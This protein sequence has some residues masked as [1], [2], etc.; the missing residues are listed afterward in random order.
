M[1]PLQIAFLIEPLASLK[2]GHDTTLALMLECHRRGHR[3]RSF[4]KQDLWVEDGEAHARCRVLGGS[5][6]PAHPLRV[7]SELNARIGSFDVVFMRADPPVDTTFIEATWLVELCGQRPPLFVNHPRG[8]REWNEKLFPLRFAELMPETLVS[9]DP[10]ALRGFVREHGEAIAKPVDGFAGQGIV[11]LKD[12]DRNLRSL[13]ELCTHGGTRRIILQRYLPESRNGDKRILVLDGEPL[14]AV[15]R[16]PLDS[17]VRANMAV[18]GKAERTEVTEEDA[19]MCRKLAPALK[20]LGL[21]LVGVD[22]IGR[23]ITEVNVTSPTGLWE[24]NRLSGLRLEEQVFDWVEERVR[25]TDS[26]RWPTMLHGSASF[27]P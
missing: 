7:E 12:R 21:W 20:G 6:D 14:G 15:M 2:A 3:L 23:Y 16:V 9:H 1:I 26:G 24:I 8:L 18:G 17:E 27:V 4:E 25:E 22:V 5:G 13:L 11:H 19:L 10:S